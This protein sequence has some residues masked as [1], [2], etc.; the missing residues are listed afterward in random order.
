MLQVPDSKSASPDSIGGTVR[1]GH[2]R[3]VL[4]R[5]MDTLWDNRC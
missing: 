3:Q 4:G 5:N 2:M 1:S